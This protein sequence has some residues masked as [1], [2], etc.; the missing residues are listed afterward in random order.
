VRLTA[1]A[2]AGSTFTG[3]SGGGCSGTGPCTVTVTDRVTVTATFT[4]TAAGP[5]TLTVAKTGTAAAGGTVS[6][7]PAGI[8]CGGT[9]SA[10]FP[11]GTPVTL[12]AT[13]AAGS[14]FTGWSGGGC[15]NSPTQCSL[16]LTANTNVTANFELNGTIEIFNQV[17]FDNLNIPMFSGPFGATFGPLLVGSG[18]TVPLSNA[19]PG[20]YTIPGGQHYNSE[21]SGPCPPFSFSVTPGGTTTVTYNQ[22]EDSP[23]NQCSVATGGQAPQKRRGR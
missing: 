11:S 15:P 17:E 6:S 3:W 7:M 16:T 19:P 2:A 10:S 21:F 4:G 8:N 13:A 23:Q 1:T 12:T 5:A 20:N 14:V 9:C 18:E 22:I